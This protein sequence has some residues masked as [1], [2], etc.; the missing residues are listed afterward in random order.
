MGERRGDWMEV[1][2][3]FNLDIKHAKLVKGKGLCKF[4]AEA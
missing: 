4:P 2:Q 1:V 3:E